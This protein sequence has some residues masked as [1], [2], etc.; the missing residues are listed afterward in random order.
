MNPTAVGASVV[1]ELEGKGVEGEPVVG[2][3]E[4]ETVDKVGLLGREVGEYLHH[5]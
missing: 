4:D 1:G 5:V 3:A 2:C